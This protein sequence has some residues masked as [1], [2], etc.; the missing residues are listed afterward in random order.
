MTGA[1]QV[2]LAWPGWPDCHLF[3]GRGVRHRLAR[4]LGFGIPIGAASPKGPLVGRQPVETESSKHGRKASH[5]ETLSTRIERAL[6]NPTDRIATNTSTR[7]HKSHEHHEEQYGKSSRQF[8]ATTTRRARRQHDEH[9]RRLREEIAT[10]DDTQISN[11]HRAY[12]PMTSERIYLDAVYRPP[13][14][15]SEAEQ[16]AARHDN[17]QKHRARYRTQTALSHHVIASC[18]RLIVCSLAHVAATARHVTQPRIDGTNVMT[19]RGSNAVQRIN[20]MT[21]RQIQDDERELEEM[22]MSAK[23]PSEIKHDEPCLRRWHVD[24][25]RHV[26]NALSRHRA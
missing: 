7:R 22:R 26:V 19:R 3:V 9:Q 16:R 18:A 1:I 5:G 15:R 25:V 17:C 12:Q 20:A 2:A 23:T 6:R 14:N 8:R 24:S 10:R 13:R 11:Q 21:T 4:R